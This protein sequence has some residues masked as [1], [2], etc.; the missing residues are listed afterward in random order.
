MRRQA[1]LAALAVLST[2]AVIAGCSRDDGPDQAGFDV[3]QPQIDGTSRETLLASAENIRDEIGEDGD[4]FAAA[5]RY[6]LEL[7]RSSIEAAE[8]TGTTLLDMVEDGQSPEEALAKNGFSGLRVSLD[9]QIDVE[10]TLDGLTGAEAIALIEGWQASDLDYSIERLEETI[11]E[12][13]AAAPL[14]RAADMRVEGLTVVDHAMAFLDE[15]FGTRPIVAI[16]YENAS[17]QPIDKAEVRLSVREEGRQKAWVEAEGF[18]LFD[19]GLEPGE[20][21]EE[22]LIVTDVLDKGQLATLEGRNL[23]EL[24]FEFVILEAPAVGQTFEEEMAIEDYRRLPELRA[25]L[26]ENRR[27][28]AEIRSP[29]AAPARSAE[30]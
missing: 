8:E 10:R 21:R 13:E 7:E 4:R 6:L 24:Q 30:R 26:A 16:T 9:G 12:A 25:A 11:T 3:A 18:T 19:G 15:G 1:S 27:K 2:I 29:A 17:S 22:L 23:D 5:L 28:R 14:A 20:R